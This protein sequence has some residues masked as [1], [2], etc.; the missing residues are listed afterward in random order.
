[1]ATSCL[2]HINNTPPEDGPK[3]AVYSAENAHGSPHMKPM[4]LRSCFSA[5]GERQAE[6]AVFNSLVL[7]ALYAARRRDV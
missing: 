7:P 6:T 1:M 5:L 4:R 3:S 2:P